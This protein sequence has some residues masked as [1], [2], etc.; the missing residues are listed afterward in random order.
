M[1]I[2]RRAQPV[3]DVVA[4]EA[5]AARAGAAM[6]CAFSSAAEFDAALIAERR[7]AGVYGPRRHRKQMLTTAAGIVVALA[8][9]IFLIA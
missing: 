8:A 4:L 2:A 1:L 7:A 5:Y 9:I 6:A 3:D